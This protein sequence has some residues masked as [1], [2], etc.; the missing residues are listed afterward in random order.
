MPSS[1]RPRF[2]A[3]LVVF[4]C[5]F[6]G[7]SH[8][9]P[10]F[11]TDDPEPVEFH[12]WEIYFATQ[13]SHSTGDWSGTAP[14]LELNFGVLPNV[15]LHLIAPLAYDHPS[16]GPSH[17]GYGDTELGFKYRFV[18]ETESLPQIGIFPLVELPSG[19]S[20][21]G[22]GN[23]KTQLFLPLWMQKKFGDWTT[24]GGGGYWFNPG[25]DNR[26]YWYAGW[27]I[28]RKISESFAAGLEIQYRTPDAY[29]ARSVFALNA[30]GIWDFSDTYHILFSAGHS[31]NGPGEFQGYLG[32][33][34]TFGPENH[35]SPAAK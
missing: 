15:Q 8:A 28:Q 11:V 2:L 1:R 22:L 23:G 27:E 3:L 32:F 10:P 24:Y 21:K 4:T 20:D 25:Q 26:N 30:G 18:Q 34:I 12:H 31:V 33:Q 29:A 9:G 19:N 16:E 5:V 14:H 6:A 17:C 35:K 13:Q 7:R